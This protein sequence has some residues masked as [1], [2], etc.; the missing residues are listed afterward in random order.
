MVPKGKPVVVGDRGQQVAEVGTWR[1]NITC[2]E[3]RERT[4][5]GVIVKT[6]K[7]ISQ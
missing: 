7:A 4:G 1:G 2:R 6:L 5:C 3:H